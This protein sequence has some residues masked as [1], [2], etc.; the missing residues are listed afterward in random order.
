M[1]A[2]NELERMEGSGGEGTIPEFG[3]EENHEKL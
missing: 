3:A 1:I 2:S